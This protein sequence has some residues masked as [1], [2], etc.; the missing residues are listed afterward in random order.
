VTAGN[1]ILAD[2]VAGAEHRDSGFLPLLGDYCH[3][4]LAL[5]NV[6]DGIRGIAL[7][8]DRFTLRTLDD[9]FVEPGFRQ[10]LDRIESEFLHLAGLAAVQRRQREDNGCTFWTG[11]GTRAACIPFR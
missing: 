8:E 11:R 5:L 3:L 10:E 7:G 1:A 9:G 6:E 2:E 4:G